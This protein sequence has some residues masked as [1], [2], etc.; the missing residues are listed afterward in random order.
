ML[1][2]KI[3]VKGGMRMYVGVGKKELTCEGACSWANSCDCCCLGVFGRGGVT[4]SRGDGEWTYCCCCG[5]D[6]VCVCCWCCE[7][8]ANETGA[9]SSSS[10]PTIHQYIQIKLFH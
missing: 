10:I 4:T 7:G 2:S 3:Y 5:C 1:T 8:C 9:T 6:V